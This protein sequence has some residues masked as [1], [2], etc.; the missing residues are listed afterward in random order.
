MHGT[1]Y[2]QEQIIFKGSTLELIL[3]SI[4]HFNE[5]GL[6]LFCSILISLSPPP[7]TKYRDNTFTALSLT[8]SPNI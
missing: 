5:E 3:N 1:P 6:F 2:N 4:Q 7:G 8:I